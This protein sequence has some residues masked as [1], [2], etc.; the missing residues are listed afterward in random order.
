MNQFTYSYPTKVYFG[1]GEAKQALP[2]C[3]FVKHI[4][5]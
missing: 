3:R 4:G 5:Q 2:Q 1:E